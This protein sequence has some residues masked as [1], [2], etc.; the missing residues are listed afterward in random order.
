MKGVYLPKPFQVLSEIR[1]TKK[2]NSDDLFPVILTARRVIRSLH[3]GYKAHLLEIF[4]KSKND[5]KLRKRN[6][7]KKKLSSKI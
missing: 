6:S 5:R 2:D 7:S 4:M 1:E 3:T